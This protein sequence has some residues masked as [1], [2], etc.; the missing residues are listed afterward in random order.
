[1][2]ETGTLALPP[3]SKEKSGGERPS[4]WII[5]LLVLTLISIGTGAGFG[6]VLASRVEKTVESKLTAAAEKNAPQT[7]Y[8]GDLTLRNLPPIVTNLASSEDAWVRLESAIVFNNGDTGAELFAG[9]IRQ[10]ILAYLRSVSLA[11]IQG[12]SG[13]LHLREDL[14]ERVQLR[15]K[16]AVKELVIQTLIVQ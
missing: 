15:T 3:A 13:L 9:E 14:N 5:T 7:P 16:G 10:D 2:A 4:R 11:Q 8:A 12:A 6:Y 1:M